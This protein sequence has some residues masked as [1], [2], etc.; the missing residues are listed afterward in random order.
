MVQTSQLAVEPVKA[1]STS[2]V[3]AGDEVDAFGTVVTRIR[4]TFV[5]V[6]VASFAC[7]TKQPTVVESLYYISGQKL[8]IAVAQGQ[9]PTLCHSKIYRKL[10]LSYRAYDTSVLFMAASPA[11]P[12]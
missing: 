2:A 6:H 3:V 8:D 4:L 9:N 10:I 11:A 7:F 1:G 5:D 12:W